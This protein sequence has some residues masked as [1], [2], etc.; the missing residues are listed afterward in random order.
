L[1]GVE[2]VEVSLERGLASIRFREGRQASLARIREA[3]HSA[4]FTP[5]EA[6]LWA[7]GTVSRDGDRTLLRVPGQEA[8]F[9]LVDHADSPNVTDRLRTEARDDPVTVQGSVPESPRRPPEPPTLEVRRFQ[10]AAR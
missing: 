1:E 4:G 5:R 2:A 3:I 9:V 10:P 8:P 6:E 7:T